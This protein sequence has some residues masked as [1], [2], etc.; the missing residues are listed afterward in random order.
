MFCVLSTS[1]ALYIVYSLNSHTDPKMGTT[2]SPTLQLG[3]RGFENHTPSLQ[4]QGEPGGLSPRPPFPM[5]KEWEVRET[6]WVILSVLIFY[7][8]VF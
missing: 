3:K 7:Q 6:F 4:S 8:T 2:M 1:Q 5:L